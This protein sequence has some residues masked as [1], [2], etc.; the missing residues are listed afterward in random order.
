LKSTEQDPKFVDM[1]EKSKKKDDLADAL[2]HS[3]AF[4]NNVKPQLNEE[5]RPA[6]I[7]NI[8]PVMPS[9]AQMKSGKYTQGGLKFLAKGLLISFETF[10]TGGEQIN[11]FY[12]ACYKYFGTL[13][14]AYVQL[15]GR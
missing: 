4:L 14:N 6:A 8:K 3:L 13:D 12:K 2:L 11:G 15:G 10:E 7:R 1:F 5:R 9:L